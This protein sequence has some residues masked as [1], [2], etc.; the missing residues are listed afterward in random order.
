[1]ND[2]QQ[3]RADARTYITQP[4]ESVAGIALRQCGS[5][6]EWRNII[7]LNPE[8]SE[9]TACDYFPVGT[10]LTLPPL[11]VSQST[12]SPEPCAHDYVRKD[13]VCTECGEKT[14]SANE[15]GAEGAAGLAH[16]LWAA[17]QLAPGEGIEDGVRRIEAIVSRSPAM[18]AAAPADERAA[19]KAAHPYLDMSEKL[20]AWKRPVFAHSHV[21]AMFAGWHAHAVASSHAEIVAIYQIL[22]EEGAWLDVP[23]RL[24]DRKKSDPALTRVVYLAP[25]PPKVSPATDKAAKTL[26]EICDAALES[27]PT[28]AKLIDRL[29]SAARDG[30]PSSVCTHQSTSSNVMSIADKVPGVVYSVSIEQGPDG[31]RN[32]RVHDVADTQRDREAVA[33]AMREAAEIISPQP[34]QADTIQCQAHSGPDCTEC[35]GTGIWPAQADAPADERWEQE[36]LGAPAEAREPHSDD[37]AVDS[38]AAVMKHKLALAR[39][40]G[41]GGWETCSPA[42][43]SRMLREHVEK[44]DP[45]DVANLA[46]M[47]WHHGAPIAPAIDAAEAGDVPEC[48]GSHDAGQIA[49][50]DKE[51]TA[52]GE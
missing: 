39:A 40:K 36:I 51:C 16:E 48:N 21:E 7:A 2:Q 15:T 24:Y 30:E 22:T 11:P 47:I 26:D 50:G 46:M 12:A 17:A 32:V 20:D 3:S 34:A 23:R 35:G 38:F 29:E 28:D 43:L 42:D 5:E 41:R 13:L 18:A 37:I 19:F 25:Q 33:F 45:R 8:F 14:T 10:V 6:D 9:H 1:M 27:I 4:G 49:A 52:C 31:V 44:G